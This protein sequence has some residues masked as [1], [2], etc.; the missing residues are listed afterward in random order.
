MAS[1]SAKARD[2]VEGPVHPN[3]PAESAPE[4]GVPEALTKKARLIGLLRQTDGAS[5][6]AIS[7]ELGWLPHTTRS[8]ITGLRKAGYK[9]ETLASD[10]GTAYRT[11]AE[12]LA[13]AFDVKA[14]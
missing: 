9:V 11:P 5:L 13:P 10:V 12:P 7:A 1:T 3:Q 14:E 2:A 4:P 8:A 6:A